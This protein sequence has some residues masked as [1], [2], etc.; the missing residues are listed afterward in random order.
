MCTNLRH[1]TILSLLVC[2]FLLGGC[3]FGTR[4]PTLT[5]PPEPDSGVTTEAHAAI[6]PAA[7][8]IQIILKP[9]L[10]Q[11]SDKKVVG[12]VRN[13]FGM[14]TADVVPTNDVAGWVTD[15]VEKE[16][17]ERGYS[18]AR[19]TADHDPADNSVVVISGEVLNVFCDMYMSYT[20]QVSIIIEVRNGGR[21]LLKRHYSGE[22]SAGLAFAA[23]EKSYA[24]SLAAALFATLEKFLLDMETSI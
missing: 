19:E 8:N 17:Q 11:R 22:G 3:A 23:T 6:N 5:Y 12:T 15:A 21:E 14:R 4:N 10:D 20:G 24:Q 13:A 18:V 2:L 1:V 16:L 7:K 9:F